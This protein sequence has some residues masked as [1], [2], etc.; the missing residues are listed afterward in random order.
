[1]H[2]FITVKEINPWRGSLFP[3]EER[4]KSKFITGIKLQ[5]KPPGWFRG[6]IFHW[7]KYFIQSPHSKICLPFGQFRVNFINFSLIE[8]SATD[9]SAEERERIVGQRERMKNDLDA[10]GA[11]VSLELFHD[12]PCTSA[13][14]TVQVQ[15]DLHSN[16]GIGWSGHLDPW[17]MVGDRYGRNEMDGIQAAY[18]SCYDQE[19]HLAFRV[20]SPGS[21]RFSDHWMKVSS[22]C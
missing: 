14:R 9:L 2:E 4:W 11:E 21:S 3:Q 1:M 12:L 8:N 5:F 13:I 6:Q 20:P 10:F 19:P 22:S 18:Q 16:P 17:R 7:S 15:H